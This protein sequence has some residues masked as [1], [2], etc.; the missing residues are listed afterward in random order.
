V[1]GLFSPQILA[2]S[3]L[4]GLPRS[5]TAAFVVTVPLLEGGSRRGLRRERESLVTQI[6]AERSNAERQARSETRAAQE[7]VL[8]TD[9]ALQRARAA[10][11][12]AGEVVRITDIAF[13]E[14]AT[15][16]IEVVD[17]QRRARDAETAAAIAEDALRRA[18]LELLVATGRFP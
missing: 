8:S 5:W 2:P 10:A 9:R 14:G 11:E 16:N 7:A 13:R 12:Q 4:F 17:A 15:T 1:S 18:R 3:G 6:R